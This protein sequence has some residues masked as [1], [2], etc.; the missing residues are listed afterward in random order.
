MN[1]V[2]SHH[3]SLKKAYQKDE[4]IICHSLDSYIEILK[5]KPFKNKKKEENLFL[6]ENFEGLWSDEHIN[7]VYELLKT[8]EEED[9]VT[10][11]FFIKAVKNILD[12]VEGKVKKV[13]SKAYTLEQ[14]Q[15]SLIV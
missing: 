11:K 8:I 13:L 1:W 5:K 2:G 10:G 6:R 14:S 7:I 4:K 3:C 12:S 15:S 9:E